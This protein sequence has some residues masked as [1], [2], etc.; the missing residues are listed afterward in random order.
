LMKNLS[1]HKLIPETGAGKNGIR[2]SGLE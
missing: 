2:F 1:D